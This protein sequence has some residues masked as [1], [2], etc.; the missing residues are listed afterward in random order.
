MS[1]EDTPRR[2]I[3]RLRH[4]KQRFDKNAEFIWRRPTIAGGVTYEAG[5]PIPDVLKNNPAKLRRFWE[6]KRIELADFEAPNVATGV[7]EEEPKPND[8]IELEVQLV[9]SSELDDK[10]EIEGEVVIAE[11][12][13]LM[14][15]ANS[16][17]TVSEWNAMPDANR[18]VLIAQSLYWMQ[19]QGEEA[20]FDPLA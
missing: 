1:H 13:V 20:E 4:W 5:S 15:F 18:E 14:A 17:L 16:D 3:R 8:M 7:V 12:V 9:G 11:E 6:A 19:D 2:I 10:Y